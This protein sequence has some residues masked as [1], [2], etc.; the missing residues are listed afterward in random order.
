MST[1][2]TIEYGEEIFNIEI[3][4]D[5]NMIF[6]DYNIVHDMAALE[7][8]YP[9]TPALKLL[10]RWKSY[11][12][13]IVIDNVGLSKN[14][15]VLI[16][17]DWAEHV[18]PIF[19][20]RFKYDQWVH[21]AIVAA[22]EHAN[23][24][25]SVQ[26]AENAWYNAMKAVNNVG[27]SIILEGALCA[28]RAARDAVHSAFSGRDWKNLIRNVSYDALHGA[29]FEATNQEAITDFPGSVAYE[30]EK[31]WQIRHA[32]KV[33]E[34]TRGERANWPSVEVSP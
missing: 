30:A 12:I 31:N 27:G 23:S 24:A 33:L 32:L 11:P 22:R 1:D 4:D 13:D 26:S 25:S 8:G 9:D 29:A 5:F 17:A 7:F 20:E 15:L 19:H 2:I 21:E 6:L 10:Q 34:Y 3:D 16:A 28:A 18:F 14:Q